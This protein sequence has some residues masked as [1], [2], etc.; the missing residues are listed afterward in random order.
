MILLRNVSLQ[1]FFFLKNS[2]LLVK[3]MLNHLLR[4]I[5]WDW[6]ILPFYFKFFI[7]TRKVFFTNHYKMDY[8]WGRCHTIL[9]LRH[10]DTTEGYRG[11]NFVLT[12]MS[13]WH[14]EILIWCNSRGTQFWCGS[15]MDDSSWHSGVK[16]RRRIPW[17]Y[18]LQIMR[19]GN[20]ESLY[21]LKGFMG[22]EGQ[23]TVWGKAELFDKSLALAWF[24]FVVHETRRVLG[25]RQLR[26]FSR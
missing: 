21:E 16:E 12:T 13:G 25:N 10:P 20:W 17:L 11:L 22:E 3:F 1:L 8:N 2:F 26:Y 15:M 5:V 18:G 24:L 19:P 7:S 23:F 4:V 9:P 6:V 14:S